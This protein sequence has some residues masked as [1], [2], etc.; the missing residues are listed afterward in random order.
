MAQDHAKERE[1][2]P[3]ELTE[4]DLEGVSAGKGARKSTAPSLMPQ[5]FTGALLGMVGAPLG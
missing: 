4:K 1:H 2:E 3:A 5:G